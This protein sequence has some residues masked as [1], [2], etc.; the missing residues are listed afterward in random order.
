MFVSGA[1]RDNLAK[2][3]ILASEEGYLEKSAWTSKFLST[4]ASGT[5]RNVSR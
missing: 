3:R 5:K 1:F 2:L 4:N